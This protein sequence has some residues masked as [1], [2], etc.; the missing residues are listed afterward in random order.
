M[1]NNTNYNTTDGWWLAK[2][3]GADLKKAN[4]RL[5]KAVVFRKTVVIIH[6]CHFIQH[7]VCLSSVEGWW[8]GGYYFGERPCRMSK[9]LRLR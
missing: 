9:T 2:W 7:G 3:I 4:S 6:K 8:G 1:V 5:R